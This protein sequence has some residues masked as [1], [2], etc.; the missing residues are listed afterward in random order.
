MQIN[1]PN[2][3]YLSITD[4]NRAQVDSVTETED[5]HA[6]HLDGEVW[7]YKLDAIDPA[8]ADDFFCHIL[9][10]NGTDYMITDF[11]LRSGTA[12]G[13]VSVHRVSG[14]PTF[15]G[16][17]AEVSGVS[18]NTKYDPQSDILF[19]TDTDITIASDEGVVF[20]VEL[21]TVGAESHL[22]TSAGLI[23]GSNGSY[24]LSWSGATGTISG[25]VSITAV[26][27]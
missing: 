9:N 26:R 20:E 3:A 21:N 2:G 25:I 1:D 12:G 16:S 8:A 11:R 27:K 22:R 15:T 13:V 18:R 17:E 24:A 6:N 14:T 4:E 10:T 23:L 7:S 5:R 19:R